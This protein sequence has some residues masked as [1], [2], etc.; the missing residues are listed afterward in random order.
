MR[1]HPACLLFAA[2]LLAV[3]PG[4]QAQAQA[5]L[6]LSPARLDRFLAQESSRDLRRFLAETESDGAE[7]VCRIRNGR[8]CFPENGVYA[9]WSNN[10]ASVWV[11][12]LIGGEDE[13]RYVEGRL[14]ALTERAR[15][16][17]AAGDYDGAAAG[18]V[19][20]REGEC[21]ASGGEAG[22]ADPQLLYAIGREAVRIEEA[23]GRLEGLRAEAFRPAAGA[24]EGLLRDI[25]S[26]AAAE[27]DAAFG[28]EPGQS[29]EDALPLGRSAEGLLHSLAFAAAG[30]DG[31]GGIGAGGG[32]A[33]DRAPSVEFARW[34]ARVTEIGLTATDI[35]SPDRSIIARL[36]LLGYLRAPEAYEELAAWIAPAAPPEDATEPA[37]YFDA[38]AAQ[39]RGLDALAA[40]ADAWGGEGPLRVSAGETAAFARS[41]PD[42]VRARLETLPTGA[43]FA[44]SEGRE[45]LPPVTDLQRL[46][47]AGMRQPVI[48]EQTA[49]R[50]SR[51]GRGGLALAVDALAAESGITLESATLAD[52]LAQAEH[53]AVAGRILRAVLLEAFTENSATMRH[54]EA[55]ASGRFD[56]FAA[57]LLETA[58]GAQLAGRSDDARPADGLAGAMAQ[59]L[60]SERPFAALRAGL[61]QASASFGPSQ[62]RALTELLDG[63]TGAAAMRILRNALESAG[64]SAAEA[65]A[66]LA[67]NA[68]AVIER[69]LAEAAGVS[70]EQLASIAAGEAPDYVRRRAATALAGEDEADA[71]ALLEALTARPQAVLEAE[72][73]KIET[74]LLAALRPDGGVPPDS[75]A[76]L[77]EP[78]LRRDLAAAILAA[79]IGH[80]QLAAE[81]V[82]ARLFAGERSGAVEA[83]LAP[84]LGEAPG[85][86]ALIAGDAGPYRQGVA[87]ALKQAVARALG[88]TAAERLLD[89][90]ALA[91][92]REGDVEA[93]GR[94]YAEALLAQAGLDPQTRAQLLAG[95]EEA[96]WRHEGRVRGTDAY[97]RL[98]ASRRISLALWRMQA[99]IDLAGRALARQR[100]IHGI[101]LPGETGED[102]D[103]RELN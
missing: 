1:L 85:G 76:G 41:L 54:I 87:A 2:A 34:L 96:A 38:I 23:R 98:P 94:S 55:L 100:L 14:E 42:G 4:R 57:A 28:A 35:A 19:V 65:G 18:R 66:A 48:A 43:L 89:E 24:T 8:L 69:R 15:S 37:A 97:G 33:D 26:A 81:A 25:G 52:H 12:P 11:G 7:N 75:L 60:V 95:E 53:A 40:F 59:E 83:A 64:V 9:L 93:M 84:L 10:A 30:R 6:C 13:A 62:Q 63:R 44:L 79:E 49:T 17:A 82:M 91:R 78:A 77:A 46:A 61:E 73:E 58:L 16:L 101:V 67:G 32:A 29:A 47:L 68:A 21:F 103:S 22:R 20:L 88:E 31:S 56:D 39:Y 71:D 3:V 51:L 74:G 86:P 5:D 45:D 102:A 99:A 72:R 90:E 36:T 27:I 70:E 92:L 50:V 80:P